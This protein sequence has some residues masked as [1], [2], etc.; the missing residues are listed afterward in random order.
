LSKRSE[1]MEKQ[2]IGRLGS[3]WYMLGKAAVVE[4]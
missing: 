3:E 2:I 4:A 1:D